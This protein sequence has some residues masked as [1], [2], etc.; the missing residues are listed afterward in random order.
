MGCGTRTF[1]YGLLLCGLITCGLSACGDDDDA[2]DADS[3]SRTSHPMERDGGS[4]A[5]AGGSHDAAAEPEPGADA[6]AQPPEAADLQELLDIGI[7]DYI[8]VAKP[9]GSE[10]V[11]G[12][13]SVNDGSIVYDF[14]PADGPVCFRGAPYNASLLDQGSDNLVIYLQGGG[15][16]LSII[17]QATMEAT[18]RGV[19]KLGVLDAKDPENPVGSWNILYVPYCDGSVFGGDNDF[20]NPNDATDTRQHHGVRNFSA[21]LDLAIARFPHPKKI[22][23]AGS[24]AGGWG[25]IFQRALVRSQYP[26]AEL[27]VYDDAGLG[28]SVNTDFDANEWGSSARSRPPSCEACK[29]DPNL[30][31]YVKYLLEHDPSTVVGDFSAWEDSVIMR[32]TFQTDP[33]AFRMTLKDATEIPATAFP[34][35]YKRFFIN[36]SMHTTLLGSFH[37]TQINGV[38]VAQWL[39]LMIDRD[40]DWV[41]LLE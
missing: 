26:D 25:T 40:P 36:G 33:A 15:A 34:D 22:L 41:E 4:Q 11:S 29:T 8:G 9:T 35:R 38:T 28:L 31:P 18:P 6:G 19:P 24:S 20:T 12:N 37:S 2:N 17:C 32:F 7:D 23:L 30:S 1:W 21:A 16:C 5:G 13:A 10:M 39:G 27:S 14:D 3:G